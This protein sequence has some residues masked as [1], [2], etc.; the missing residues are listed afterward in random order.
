M[1]YTTDPGRTSDRSS[2]CAHLPLTIG[3]MISHRRQ[4]DHADPRANTPSPE[5]FS[6]VCGLFV[7]LYAQLV[8]NNIAMNGAHDTKHPRD[9]IPHDR[10]VRHP[11]CRPR[12]RVSTA[13]PRGCASRCASVRMEAHGPFP[14]DL[15]LL[16]SLLCH[17]KWLPLRLFPMLFPGPWVKVSK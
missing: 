6:F 12:R 9:N 4:A 16:T 10:N 17:E 1:F 15:S 2:Q 5:P 14:L 13:L 7:P 3:D 8:S 11:L